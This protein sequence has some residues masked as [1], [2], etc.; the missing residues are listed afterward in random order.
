MLLDFGL[1]RTASLS[2]HRLGFRDVDRGTA[3]GDVEAEGPAYVNLRSDKG[4]DELH[5]AGM[6]Y[7]SDRAHLRQY[8]LG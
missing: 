6:L 4:S 8:R 1:G 2:C 7:T 3:A 5:L